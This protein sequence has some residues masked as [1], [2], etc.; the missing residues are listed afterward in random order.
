MEFATD[1][2]LLD[3]NFAVWLEPTAT[4][5]TEG[6]RRGQVPGW[7]ELPPRSRTLRDFDRT[8]GIRSRLLLRP[9]STFPFSCP[10][11]ARGGGSARGSPRNRR[12]RTVDGRS[13]C[14]AFHPADD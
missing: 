8:C 12:L 4:T 10:P 6:R 2:T 9:F 14:F 5:F 11:S 1:A 3:K 7:T 13:R